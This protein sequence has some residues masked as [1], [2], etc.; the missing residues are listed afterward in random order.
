M[1]IIRLKK[2]RC[3]FPNLTEINQVYIL[4]LVEGLKRAQGKTSGKSLVKKEAIK[5]TEC[6]ANNVC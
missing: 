6:E 2:F 1:S 4:G 5:Y 3:V